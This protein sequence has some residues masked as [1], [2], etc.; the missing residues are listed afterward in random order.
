MTTVEKLAELNDKLKKL[1]SCLR[2]MK[3]MGCT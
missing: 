1:N 2:T 3:F